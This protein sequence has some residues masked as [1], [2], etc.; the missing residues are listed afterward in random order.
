MRLILIE[1]NGIEAEAVVESMRRAG[2]TVD[3]RR[4]RGS[5]E[6]AL[7]NESYDVVLL[8]LDLP[9]SESI[10]L[11]ITYRKAGGAAST[12]VL[13]D[14]QQAHER[15]H[16]LY[17]GADDHMTR[18]L[19]LEELSVRIH[20]LLRRRKGHKQKVLRHRNLMLDPTAQ[21]FKSAGKQLYLTPREFAVMHALMEEPARVLS[22]AE[23]E[24]RIY[25]DANEDRTNAIQVYV[26]TLRR[27]I[28]EDEIL[29]VRGVGYRL[30]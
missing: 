16:A 25:G 3:W 2:Y 27:K 29:T 23:I 6:Q 28:G 1:R 7:R 5:A 12:L 26:N 13:T 14:H 10:E 8:A 9:N 21:E 24:Q 22:R 4:D 18:P 15:I 17:A 30:A 11:L 20:M 19:N